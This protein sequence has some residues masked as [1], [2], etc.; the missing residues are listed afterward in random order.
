MQE[1]DKEETAAVKRDGWSAEEVA[2]EA[3]NQMADEVQRQMARGDETKGDPDE[4][5][6][7]GRPKENETPYERHQ[8]K[9]VEG[10]AENYGR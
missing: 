4:R 5:D 8:T 9:K 10:E 1:K 3:S 2:E 6:V 7:V